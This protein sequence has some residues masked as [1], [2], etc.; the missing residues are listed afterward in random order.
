MEIPFFIVLII[1]QG[2]AGIIGQLIIL[3]EL[4]P[5]YYGN[6]L[7]LGI[8]L[9]SWLFWVALGSGLIGKISYYVKNTKRIYCLITIFSTVILSLLLITIRNLR[10]FLHLIP[11]E[12]VSFPLIILSSFLIVAPYALLQGLLFTIAPRMCTH[13]K[14]IIDNTNSIYLWEALGA[15]IGCVSY[16]FIGLKYFDSFQN[17]FFVNGLRLASLAL[18]I[19]FTGIKTFH[20]R[21]MVYLIFI[22][23]LLNGALIPLKGLNMFFHK[24]AYQPLTVTDIGESIY[25]NIV[26]TQQSEKNITFF[27][28][29]LNLFTTDDI[30][31]IEEATQFALLA[32][33]APRDILLL[34]G[35]I[36]GCIRKIRAHPSV[37]HITYVELDPL[38]V[39]KAIDH[40]PPDAQEMLSPENVAIHY[41]DARHFIKTTDQKFDVIISQLPEPY[42][43]QLNRFYTAEFFQEVKNIL[44]DDGILSFSIS[45]AESFINNNQ[46]LLLKSLYSTLQTSFDTIAIVPGN[47]N[48]FL[49]TNGQTK[50]SLESSYYVETIHERNLNLKYINEYFLPARL[51][52]D[53]VNYIIMRLLQTPRARINRDFNPISYFYDMI[54][55]SEVSYPPLQKCITFLL[56]LHPSY[57]YIFTCLIFLI[58]LF[59]KR[60]TSLKRSLLLTVGAVGLSE[61]SLE[62]IIILLF[63][64]FLGY[65]YSFIGI[66]IGG[67]MGGIT[68]GAY[69]GQRYTKTH[70]AIIPIYKRIIVLELMIAVVPIIIIILAHMLHNYTFSQNT[71]KMTLLITTVVTG[72]IGGMQFPCVNTLYL[73]NTSPCEKSIGLIY[74]FDLLGSSLGAF[75][76]SAIVIPLFGIQHTLIFISFINV[77]CF[78]FLV[79]AGRYR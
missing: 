37:H 36:N 39:E 14:N 32:H 74:A 65:I 76:I 33:S 79:R 42:T 52:D 13:K 41:G 3:R 24:Q 18:F 58:L 28:N 22:L 12:I 53:K 31:T 68:I 44:N 1:M 61:I 56:N 21:L 43:L 70:S 30:F 71:I 15:L 6:E 60:G 75:L 47:T 54:L 11:G 8:I 4:P 5:I 2:A 10:H 35:G 62:I 63:Q 66:I 23:I 50:L 49:A 51:T 19:L 45:S 17:V 59:G 77:L 26:I 72:I 27:E 73:K 7:S 20:H 16:Y 34:G 64:V 55:W 67:Y 40:L 25:G 78:L 38:L 46:A 48:I 29:G 69:L 57:F 9:T